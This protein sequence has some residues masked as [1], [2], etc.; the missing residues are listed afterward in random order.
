[1]NSTVKQNIRW[2]VVE[3]SLIVRQSD[4]FDARRSELQR[5]VTNYTCIG[6]SDVVAV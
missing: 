1:L 6:T 3:R 5:A 4:N 2:I